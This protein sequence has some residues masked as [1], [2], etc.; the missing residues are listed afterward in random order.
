MGVDSHHYPMG[1]PKLTLSRTALKLNPLFASTM[2][3]KITITASIRPKQR[4]LRRRRRRTLPLSNIYSVTLTHKGDETSEAGQ[5]A[6]SHT[7]RNFEPKATAIVDCG[8]GIQGLWKLDPPIPLGD[9][10]ESIIADV[11]ARSAALML[12]LGSKAGTQNIDRILR[13]PGTINL[14]NKAKLKA[15]RVALPNQADW[16]QRS[17]LSAGFISAART[18]GVST[19]QEAQEERAEYTARP[20]GRGQIRVDYPPLR[21]AG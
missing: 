21:C 8:N 18:G 2:A 3:S 11:E 15:G 9:G 7:T 14:P 10:N 20:R 6:L 5:D 4:C 13:L 17:A 19:Q 16:L 1:P 12:R